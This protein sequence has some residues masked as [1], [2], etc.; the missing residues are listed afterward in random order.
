MQQSP[1]FSI[2]TLVIVFISLFLHYLFCFILK[3]KHIDLSRFL[4]RLLIGSFSASTVPT[5]ISLILC[6]FEDIEPIKHMEGV[7]IYVAFAGI[8]LI[9]IAILETFEEKERIEK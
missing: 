9:S 4:T 7:E 6:A 8:S 1:Q 3:N 2:L 5:G